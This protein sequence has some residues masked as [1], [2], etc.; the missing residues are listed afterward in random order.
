MLLNIRSLFTVQSYPKS[1]PG[2]IPGYLVDVPVAQEAVQGTVQ[3][4]FDL[5][6]AQKKDKDRRG[7][8]GRRCCLGDRID[9]IAVLAILLQDDLKKE[10]NLSYYLYRPYTNNPILQSSLLQNSRAGNLLI[11]FLSESLVFCP[12]MSE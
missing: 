1:F 9:S 6:R 10:M 11:G 2:F 3:V 7:G 5:H 8:K 12:K 4:R